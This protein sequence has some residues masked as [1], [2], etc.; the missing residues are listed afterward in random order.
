[1]IPEALALYS[2]A[3][4]PVRAHVWGRWASCPFRR[5]EGAVPERG[6][7]LEVGCGYG[8]FSC[9]LA[10]Q[11]RQRDVLGIDVDVDKIVHGRFAAERARTQGA[12][13][14]FHLEPPGEVPEGPWDAVVIVDVLYLLEPDAQAG[15]LHS[16]AEQLALGGVLVVKEMA[17]SPG[18]K[19]RWNAVQEFLAVRV[20][21]ITAG[22]QLT[23]LDPEVLAAWME[24]DDLVV[25]HE[26][27][28]RGYPHP[29]HLIVGARRRSLGA[30]GVV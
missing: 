1:V 9:H 8:L 14:D 26:R 30:G 25:R 21:R 11:S 15:L 7:V 4:L 12:R 22:E 6:R 24:K 13:C 19:A 27:L 5:I 10:L 3:P 28:D 20:L 17:T 16:C 23:F 18:W 29:H 2:E